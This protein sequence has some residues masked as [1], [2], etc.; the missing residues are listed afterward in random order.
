MHQV[1]SKEDWMIAKSE[2]VYWWCVLTKD[3]HRPIHKVTRALKLIYCSPL[4]PSDLSEDWLNSVAPPRETWSVRLRLTQSRSRSER[5]LTILSILRLSCGY[6]THYTD[7]DCNGI[8][9]PFVYVIHKNLLS[10]T[11]S[12]IP[13]KAFISSSKPLHFEI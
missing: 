12:C 3:W 4:S 9:K 2:T 6:I 13:C 1:K 7:R 10:R 8:S 5:L 11:G